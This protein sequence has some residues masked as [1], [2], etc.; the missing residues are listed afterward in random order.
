MGKAADGGE[1]GLI[2][3][4]ADGERLGPSSSSRVWATELD[5]VTRSVSV[6]VPATVRGTLVTT[7]ST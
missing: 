3:V 4:G 2:S 1:T 5:A 7:R 6:N